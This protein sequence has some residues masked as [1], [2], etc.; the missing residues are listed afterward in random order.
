[1]NFD[2]PENEGPRTA[3]YDARAE[4]NL[5]GNFTA[6]PI[7]ITNAEF[8][9]AIFSDRAA[10]SSVVYC[11]FKDDPLLRKSWPHKVW[12][13]GDI[14]GGQN[15]YFGLASLHPDDEGKVRRRKANF[16]GLHAVMLDDVGTKVDEDL[17]ITP[18]WLIESSP[19]NHQAGFILEQPLA[20]AEAT[21]LFKALTV[22]NR[23][24]D[25]GGQNVVRLAR[26]PVGCNT[27]GTL[28]EPFECELK[29]WNPAIRYSLAELVNGLGLDLAPHQSARNH[30]KTGVP[31]ESGDAVFTPRPETNPV[32]A[33]LKTRE[34]YQRP[35]GGGKH[36]ITCPWVAEHTDQI[37][38]GTVYFEPGGD[39][40][41]G[42]FKCQHGHCAHRH[43]NE[44]LAWLEV[45]DHE[46]KFKPIFRVTGGTLNLLVPNA[47]RVMA[48]TGRYF[49]QGGAL[50]MVTTPPGQETVAR[51]VRKEALPFVSVDGA[52]GL[53]ET[54][55]QTRRM[56]ADRRTRQ[57]VCRAV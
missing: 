50:V 57:G 37:D 41:R 35:L 16:A 33:A 9:A 10:D 54:E 6:P 43:I 17:P 23:L 7:S 51:H 29:V 53:A 40:I 4:A 49:Q 46:A 34:L 52:C 28:V 11:R 14:A 27:K 8:L 18:S 36:E 30:Q 25:A 56:G 48:E 47:E 22:A 1:M 39:F 5:H 2:T 3:G 32:I 55:W 38:S 21:T 12:D 42:G 26:L 13:S 20:L 31:H 19:G 45:S 44:L 15:T 24:T